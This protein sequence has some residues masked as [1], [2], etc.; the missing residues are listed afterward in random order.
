MKNLKRII[1]GCGHLKH[2]GEHPGNGWMLVFIAMGALA[3]CQHGW[4]ASLKG[5]AIMGVCMTPL[6]LMGAYDRALTE[7]ME[8]MLERTVEKIQH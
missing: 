1:R 6:Y 5:A 2:C 3:V 4:Q 7:E 8:E